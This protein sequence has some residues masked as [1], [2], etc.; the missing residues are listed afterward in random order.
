MFFCFCADVLKGKG[1]LIAI[2]DLEVHNFEILKFVNMTP[3]ILAPFEYLAW[4]SILKSSN[5][6]SKALSKG[7]AGF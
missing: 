5:Q 4:Q 2:H 3:E 7:I 1:T 6:S